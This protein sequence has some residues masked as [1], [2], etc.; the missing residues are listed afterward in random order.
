M[1]LFLDGK[2]ITFSVGLKEGT[3]SD[4]KR[5]FGL[6][7][8][9]SDGADV[10]GQNLNVENTKGKTI[11][12]VQTPGG[13]G[14]TLQ[15][16]ASIFM[17]SFGKMDPTMNLALL[18]RTSSDTAK[19]ETILRLLGPGHMQTLVMVTLGWNCLTWRGSLR[20]WAGTTYQPGEPASSARLVLFEVLG[21]AL[22]KSP[23]GLAY[24]F[25]PQAF[26]ETLR[27]I[28]VNK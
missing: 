7:G 22:S 10:R 11:Q 20:A 26:I 27:N 21:K 5:L 17:L 8:Q 12:T 6:V 15:L 28:Q 14:V 24:P 13:L 4:D 16:E 25:I 18:V 2:Y 23:L 9:P 1:F 19:W 3:F